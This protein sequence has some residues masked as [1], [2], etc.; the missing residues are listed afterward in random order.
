[1]QPTLSETEI[2]AQIQT[3]MQ[4]PHVISALRFHNL[5]TPEK[6]ITAPKTIN[7]PIPLSI[8]HILLAGFLSSF[9]QPF[10]QKRFE[11]SIRFQNGDKTNEETW[12]GHPQ[13]HYTAFYCHQGDIRAQTNVLSVNMVMRCLNNENRQ[14]LQTLYPYKKE[15]E[16]FALIAPL[17]QGVQ[18]TPELQTAHSEWMIKIDNLDLPDIQKFLDTLCTNATSPK[19][20][21]AI[22]ALQN[23][24]NNCMYPIIHNTGDL[25]VF[26]EKT[27]IRH[28]P[29]YQPSNPN[30]PRWLQTLSL[31]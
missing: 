6:S 18:F 21:T 10:A 5:P 30:K 1:M 31:T 19:H 26:N 12:H 28:S 4:K 24:L 16:P 20:K 25:T 15:Q 22:T 17:N 29:P 11:N 2:P 27:T 8:T 23:L 14:A 13:F 7:D 3:F 9:N